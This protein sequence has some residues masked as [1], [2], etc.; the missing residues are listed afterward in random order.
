M[1]KNEDLGYNDLDDGGEASKYEGLTV[2][3]TKTGSQP[4]NVIAQKNQADKEFNTRVEKA[5]ALLSPVER[6]VFKLI[7]KGHSIQGAS[8]KLGLSQ[9]RAQKCWE[10]IKSK[11]Q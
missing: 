1:H 5:E 4:L 3:K 2:F 8:A 9:Q 10:N 11:L 6:K 7:M